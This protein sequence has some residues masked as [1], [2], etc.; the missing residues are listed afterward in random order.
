[1]ASWRNHKR[2]AFFFVIRESDRAVYAVRRGPSFGVPG[3]KG[4]S[5]KDYNDLSIAVR[6][7]WE[8]TGNYPPGVEAPDDSSASGAS[9]KPP[10]P[11]AGLNDFA[12]AD[13]SHVPR[14]VASGDKHHV[15]TYFYRIVPDAECAQLRVGAAPRSE[16]AMG[17]EEEVLWVDVAANWDRVRPH[18]Q[19]GINLI[20]RD[21]S[22]A[23]PGSQFRSPSRP[24]RALRPSTQQA[25]FPAGRSPRAPAPSGVSALP[26]LAQKPGPC[27]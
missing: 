16:L 17:G 12:V 4:E 27:C 9:D 26:W 18:I 25:Y 15:C 22:G 19:K 1:M 7:F 21:C 5:D 13:K 6:E 23:I 14:F 10:S 24:S 3:G 8:E 20:R 2:V 11:S